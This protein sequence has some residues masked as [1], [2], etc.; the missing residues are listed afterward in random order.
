MARSRIRDA[1]VWKDGF[2]FVGNDLAIDFLNTRPVQEGEAT[3]LLPDFAALL[4][5]FHTAGLLSPGDVAVLEREWGQSV[6]ARR[7]AEAVRG[8]REKL[9]KEVLEW[10]QGR[11]V[12]RGAIDEVNRLMTAYPMSTRL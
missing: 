8:F 7:T 1:P 10:E 5:W 4:R 11:A 3:E 9:R 12:H 6:G 2:L